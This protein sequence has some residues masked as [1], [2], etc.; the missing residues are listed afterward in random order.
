[1]QYISDVQKI[2][3]IS[4]CLKTGVEKTYDA[5]QDVAV[6]GFNPKCIGSACGGKALTYKKYVWMYLD[7]HSKNPDGLIRKFE[8][9]QNT[10]SRPKR[11]RKVYGMHI[12]TNKTVQYDATYHAVRDG[13]SHQAI[14]KCC[15]QPSINKSYKGFVWSFN[16]KDLKDLVK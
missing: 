9:C 14:Y 13:F 11:Y 4:K 3:V 16:E 15:K 7:E 8:Q 12:K 2:S 1:K 10:K 5:I 6:D